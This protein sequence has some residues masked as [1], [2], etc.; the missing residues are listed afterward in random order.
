MLVCSCNTKQAEAEPGCQELGRRDAGVHV[1]QLEASSQEDK[2][3]AH[4]RRSLAQAHQSAQPRAQR[5]TLL[6][7]QQNGRERTC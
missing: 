6:S 4:R 2:L 7:A 3:Q 5:K 1:G